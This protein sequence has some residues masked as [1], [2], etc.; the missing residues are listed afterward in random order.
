MSTYVGLTPT[1]KAWLKRYGFDMEKGQHHKSARVD[2]YI[3]SETDDGKPVHGHIFHLPPLEGQYS[4]VALELKQVKINGMIC[5]DLYIVSKDKSG[6][7]QATPHCCSWVKDLSLKEDGVLV[8]YDS[9]R[10]CDV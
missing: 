2:L 6:K 5:T 4:R 10:Y 3:M 9:G 8:H 1:A 7:E